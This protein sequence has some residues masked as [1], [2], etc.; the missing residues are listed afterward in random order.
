MS[1]IDSAFIRQWFSE[2]DPEPPTFGAASERLTHLIADDPEAAWSLVLL[3]V[4]SAPSDAALE[5]V[6]AGP[7]E[8]LLCE[9]G[10]KLIDRVEAA[11]LQEPRVSRALANVWGHNRMDAVVRERVTR[12]AAK[13]GE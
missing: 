4:N 9:H 6:G 1:A 7:L 10:P 2:W 12:A 8:D 11:A 13:T 3:L 5:Y